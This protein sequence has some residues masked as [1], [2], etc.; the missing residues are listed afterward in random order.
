MTAVMVMGAGAT[1][2][3]M[4]LRLLLM[5]AQVAGATTMLRQLPTVAERILGVV[6]AA[7]GRF[8][9]TPWLRA[10]CC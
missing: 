6:A 7:D 10:I 5:A 8:F 9:D 1:A 3:T 4:P 2:T